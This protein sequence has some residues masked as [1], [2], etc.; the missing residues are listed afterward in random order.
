MD[1][2]S[3]AST[4]ATSKSK[5][6]YRIKEKRGDITS[7]RFSF[8]TGPEAP[9]PWLNNHLLCSVIIFAKQNL[10]HHHLLA[11]DNIYARHEGDFG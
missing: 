11:G 6:H 4:T 3:R 10:A 2:V 7:S 8:I 1:R 5:R 9:A